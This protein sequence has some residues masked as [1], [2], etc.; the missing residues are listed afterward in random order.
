MS[1]STASR[2]QPGLNDAAPPG[3]AEPTVGRSS[4]SRS[5]QAFSLPSVPPASALA[6]E[7]EADATA[8]DT[9]QSG[10]ITRSG[11]HS[12]NPVRVVPGVP[13][14]G[15]PVSSASGEVTSSRAVATSRLLPM[16]APP[17][18]SAIPP[19]P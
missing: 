9:G 8:R 16:P 4:A 10:G 11:R 14:T 2:S 6:S 7:R 15:S 5:A 18:T 13:A 12:P 1:P 17:V 19:R 3:S